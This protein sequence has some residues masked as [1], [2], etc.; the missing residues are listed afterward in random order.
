MSSLTNIS[1]FHLWCVRS[2]HIGV[3]TNPYLC[4]WLEQPSRCCGSPCALHPAPTFLCKM[5]SLW[6]DVR[7]SGDISLFQI[8]SA[9]TAQGL[10]LPIFSGIVFIYRIGCSC[11]SRF[12]LRTVQPASFSSEVY[13]N[14]YLMSHLQKWVSRIQYLLARS[15]PFDR[16]A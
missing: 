1:C 2:E 16:S 11:S 9:N 7:Y 6:Q 13:P 12:V 4:I 15:K 10:T 3:K 5:T 14:E 8:Q